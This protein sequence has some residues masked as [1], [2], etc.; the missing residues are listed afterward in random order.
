MYNDPMQM[1]REVERDLFEM[2]IRYQS[3]TVQDQEVRGD[4]GFRTIELTGYQYSLK[5]PSLESLE[6]MVTYLNGNLEW[7]KEELLERLGGAI[8]P[9]TAWT[10]NGESRKTWEP[11][12][13]EGRFAYSYPERLTLQLDYAIAE[14]QRR[15]STRQAVMT[16]YDVHQDL[17]NWGGLDRVPCSLTYQFLLR[18]E[19]LTLIYSQRSCDFMKFFATDVYITCGMLQHAA[20]HVA[21]VRTVTSTRLIHCVGSLH[22]FAKDLD[23]R[24]IF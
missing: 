20:I 17:M 24:G 12:L 22:A 13:R 3:D 6:K 15:P 9:G 16:M 1:V 7:A 23:G 2:G 8:N 11:F 21:S 4:P 5:N 10:A 14:L 19:Q 18:D